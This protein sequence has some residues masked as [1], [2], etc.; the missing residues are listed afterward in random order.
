MATTDRRKSRTIDPD[1][2]DALGTAAGTA[3]AILN[4]VTSC[5]R[6]PLE[7]DGTMVVVSVHGA[8]SAGGGGGMP[9]RASGAE[10][11]EP[12]RPRCKR[13]TY[14]PA[15]RGSPGSPGLGSISQ[16]RRVDRVPRP[17]GP[18]LDPAIGLSHF[19]LP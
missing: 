5:W 15:D 13:G 17:G 14:W 6:E 19:L 4:A 12:L 18:R 8:E 9:A 7:D 10:S 1:E 3:M 2:H 16:G 11:Y